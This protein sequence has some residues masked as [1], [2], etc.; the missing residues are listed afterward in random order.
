MH[1]RDVKLA[2]TPPIIAQ[3]TP[4]LRERFGTLAQFERYDP[5]GLALGKRIGYD[6]GASRKQHIAQFNRPVRER[7]DAVEPS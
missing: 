7:L 5:G 3:L 4:P 2:V 6:V 1:H